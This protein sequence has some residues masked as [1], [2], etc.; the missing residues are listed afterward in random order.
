MAASS[1]AKPKRSKSDRTKR[2]MRKGIRISVAGC[3][4]KIVAIHGLRNEL[5]SVQWD[6]GG[7]SQVDS[8]IHQVVV[9]RRA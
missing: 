2:L 4:G 8:D 1:S 6:G 5:L 7:T 3:S 9:R